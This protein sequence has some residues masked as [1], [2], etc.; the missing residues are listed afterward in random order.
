MQHFAVSTTRAT[1][2]PFVFCKTCGC[3][4]AVFHCGACGAVHVAQR[5]SGLCRYFEATVRFGGFMNRK[6]AAYIGALALAAAGLIAAPSAIAG[7]VNLTLSSSTPSTTTFTISGTYAPTVPTTSISTPGGTY[8]MSFSLPTDPS[9]LSTFA[10]NTSTGY[11]DV[12]AELT[13]TLNGGTPMTFSTPFLVYFY[14]N[15]GS[16]PDM[17]GLVFCFND[18]GCASQTYWNI[19]GA[20]GQQLFTGGVTNPTF[21][22]PGLTA[23]GSVNADVNEKMSGY[24]IDNSGPF[25]FQYLPPST[26][27]EPASLFLLGTGLLGLGV[28]TRKKLRVN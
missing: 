17:G 15:T 2:K 12:A 20:G 28:F 4:I 3:P 21:G 7:T 5:K 16:L 22:I 1:V 19:I 27:P 11:F 14:T 9:S 10:S 25:P 18:G 6:Y 23:G 8:S 26:T 24:L 13:F